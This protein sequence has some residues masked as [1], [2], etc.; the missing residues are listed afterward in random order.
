MTD[1]KELYAQLAEKIKAV[2]VA[3]GDATKFAEEHGLNFIYSLGN[4][5]A[6]FVGDVDPDSTDYNY[7]EASEAGWYNSYEY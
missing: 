2:D 5:S 6:E 3:M 7:W 4:L 1:K